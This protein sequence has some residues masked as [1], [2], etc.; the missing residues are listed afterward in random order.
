MFG[1][2]Q[3]YFQLILV[4]VFAVSTIVGYLLIKNVP[5]LLHTPL[6]SGMNALSGVTVLG[7]LTATAVMFKA[8]PVL[9][10]IFGAIAIALA[11]VN[12]VGG[13]MVTDRM[14]KMIVKK[15]PKFNT[16]IYAI[17][18]VCACGIGALIY[19]S[20]TASFGEYLYLASM[21][22]LTIAVLG[23]IAMM[24]KVAISKIGNRVSAVAMLLSILLTIIYNGIGGSYSIYIGIALGSIFGVILAVKVKM[25]QMPQMVALLNGLGGAASAFVGAFAML[26]IG[27]GFDVFS[28]ITSSLALLV[29][30]VT[31]I[32]SLVAAGKLHKILPQKPIIFKKHQLLTMGSLALTVIAMIAFCILGGKGEK[33]YLV[34][35]IVLITIF[36]SLFGFFFSIRVGGADMPITIS[37]LNS[38][39]G[40][41]GAIAG[42]AINDLLLVAVGGIVGASG[43]LLTQIMCKAMNRS[44]TA[45]LLGSTSAS[46]ST[47]AKAVKETKA[48]AKAEKADETNYAKELLNAK[49]VIIVPG[50]GMAIAQAQHLVKK[51][52]D[53]LVA[54]GT[55]VRYAVH[56]V[57]GRM[58][59]H[60]NVLLCEANVEYED[61]FEMEDINGDFASADATIVV[62]ANDVMNPA[63]REAEGTPIYGMPVLSV[64]TCKNVY[65]FNYDLKPGYAGVENPL[66]SRTEGVHL[67][68]GNAQET[69]D[70]FMKE[71]DAKDEA[72]A[73]EIKKEENFA[74]DLLNAKDVII[75]PGY[76]MAIAQA[77]HLVKK[78]A[79][80]LVANGTKV[81]YA[82]HP[83][84]GRMPGHMNV[85]LC[86]ANVEYEDLFEMEDINGDFA[87]ADATIVVGANDVMNPA[88]RE[89]EGTPI[90]GMPVLSVDSCKKVYIFNYDLKPGY[91]GVENPLYSRTEG[92]HLYLGNAQETLDKFIKDMD[93]TDSAPIEKA[94]ETNYAKLLL[95]A[96]DVIIVPG[97]GM[98]IAQAQHLVKKLADKLVANGTKVRYAVHPVAGRMPGHMNVLLCEANVEYEDLF[99]MEDINGDFASADATIVVGANDVMNPAAREAEG[100]PIYGMPVLSVDTC[101][102]VYIFNYDL[103]PGYAGVE[104]PLYS[105]TEGVHLYLGNAQETLNA[106][107]SD[108]DK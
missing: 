16:L 96:K 104:N 15:T 29:G 53:K 44:L 33:I 24:S 10:A 72:P 43:L 8:N 3:I 63:A 74:K 14:L 51:L 38:F 108:M 39:S 22:L 100:T 91:A 28:L 87:S 94:D 88:A 71:M 103:K 58:P 101:K 40:V 21:V 80:K 34:G 26:G 20:T 79:D 67:Y 4:G 37:L 95:D 92:V 18:A 66:Y 35:G 105:R 5:G 85:L 77:Q 30:A 59:G 78:L 12:V 50:Y 55:K 68:L 83:V 13:F 86:E 90:Y 99:E 69:L 102:N 49:D 32:G 27:S 23:G 7:A 65:I 11:M 106:F 41:A 97:Y 9:S 31:L 54:N 52:A 84:A 73:V 56:P 2:E 17:T 76:G 107:I 61:L 19:F 46:S 6:M 93:A 75:V 48:E 62:G 57:A 82:V 64:D 60:M 81:R 98:A 1:L 47:P 45:I 70:K 42:L 36:A 89:A 25:I